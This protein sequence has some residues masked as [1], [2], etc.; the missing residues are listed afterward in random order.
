MEHQGTVYRAS[1]YAAPFLVAWLPDAQAEEKP[2]LVTFLARLARGNSYKRQHLNLTDEQRRRD[3]VFQ[4]EIAEEI[5]WVELIHQAVWEGI[6]LYLA[7]LDDQDLQLRM[8]TTYLLASFKEDRARMTPLLR[9]SLERE[10]DERMMGCLLLSLGQRQP[11]TEDSSA[12]LM[13]YLTG[14][15][16][17]LVRFCAAMALSSLLREAVPEEVV[18]VFFTVLTDPAS[19][20]T[21]YD[22]LPWTWAG[23][24]P[25][26]HAFEFLGWLTSSRH[27]DLIMEQFMALLPT[28]EEIVVGEVADQLL[29]SAFHWE[30]FE[31]PPQVVRENL[32]TEQ[33][34]VLHALA[35]HD[36]LWVVEQALPGQ[37][38]WSGIWQDLL[39]LALP[40]TQQ[41][42]QTFLAL[43]PP[44]KRADQSSAGGTTG[45]KTGV[46]DAS[47]TPN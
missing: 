32:N 12:L 39:F 20:Q 10:A 47:G 15:Q 44:Q 43:K 6:D 29:H 22:E 21:A 17:P 45:R 35:A 24:A 5:R 31:P 1:A 7:F 11:T 16:T 25:Q 37:E 9:V 30:M 42:L 4:Q 3:P 46:R 23:R 40:T 27:H 28:L 18:R 19:V 8:A 34:A 33:R 14:D 13:P 41:D 38:T 2:Y 36:A 26:F